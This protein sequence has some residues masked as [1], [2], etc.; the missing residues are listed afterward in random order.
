MRALL[1]SPLGFLIG[2]SLGALGGG[3]SILAVPV[4]VYAAGQD[5]KAATA[6]SLLLVGVASLVGMGSHWRAGR[7]RIGT[8]V[9]FGLIGVAGSIAGTAV[10]R[11]ID[12]DLLLLAFAGLVCVAAWR[13]L[14]ACP[15][16][17][18]VGETI[19]LDKTNAAPGTT[20]TRTAPTTRSA[21]H[22]DARLA[23]TVLAAGTAVGFLTGLFGVGGGFVIVPALALLLKLPMPEAIGTSLLVVSINAA[24]ALTTRLA[25][26]TIDWTVTIPFTV[27]AIAGVLTGGK[28]ADRLDARRSLRAFATLLVAVAAYTALDAAISLAT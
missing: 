1:V 15:T 6:T 7:V 19:E 5:P 17:T 2:L 3:G 9:V 14:T 28:V 16:C 21:V 24:I 20:A 12:P 11:N 25:T 8:G 26:T 22:L 13:M 4:L 23:F 27:A 10:N 18:K